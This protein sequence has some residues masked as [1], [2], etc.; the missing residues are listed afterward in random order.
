MLLWLVT[1]QMAL[2]AGQWVTLQS[3]IKQKQRI[4]NV[5]TS[6]QT[7][8]RP[9][10]KGLLEKMLNIC[11]FS[12]EIL[13]FSF[14]KYKYSAWVNVLG[15]ISPL[16]EGRKGSNPNRLMSKNYTILTFKNPKLSYVSSLWVSTHN[17]H[18]HLHTYSPSH[19][20]VCYDTFPAL[21]RLI[22]VFHLIIFKRII[23]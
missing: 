13:F 19:T 12:C 16:P 20:K 8:I 4:L 7:Q 14:F 11:L 9:P 21:S 22:L 1:N 3:C 18:T 10:W 17:T 15:Y 2:W 6:Q 5:F 23:C